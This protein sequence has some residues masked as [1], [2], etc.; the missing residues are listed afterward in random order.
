MET[1]QQP[2]HEKDRGLGVGTVLFGRL[3]KK[4]PMGFGRKEARLQSTTGWWYTMDNLWIIYGWS[5]DNLWII[6]S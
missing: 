5:M 1:K 3:F 4:I 2:L 6:Y